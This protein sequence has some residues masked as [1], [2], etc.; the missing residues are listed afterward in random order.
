MKNW[1]GYQKG[2]LTVGL[3]AG[4]SAGMVVFSSTSQAAPPDKVTVCHADGRDGTIK[5]STIVIAPSAAENHLDPI[6]GTP[7]A[8]HEDDILGVDGVCPGEPTPTPT[9]TPTSTPTPTPG[10]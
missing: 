2:L 3:I 4:V 5:F 9:P 6:T 10:V 8:G 1:T 7:K